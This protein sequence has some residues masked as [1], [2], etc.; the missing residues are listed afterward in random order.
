MAP[1]PYGTYEFN[2]G[3]ERARVADGR[4]FVAASEGATFNEVGTL[5]DPTFFEANYAIDRECVI[6]RR[7]PST[8]ARYEVR[9]RFSDGFEGANHVRDLVGP[10]R[11]WTGFT[12][13]SPKAPSVDAYVHLRD[14]I[15]SN[16]CDFVDAR[17]DVEGTQARSG[18]RALKATAAPKNADLVTSK[19][20]LESELVYFVEGDD[21][22]FSAA[23]LLAERRPFTL[24]DLESSWLDLGPGP[25]LAIDDDGALYVELKFGPKPTFRQAGPN[26]VAVPIGRWFQ[27]EVRYVLKA[28]DGGVIEVS[29][30]G[31]LILSATGWTLPLPNTILNSLEVGISATN[32][33]DGE[34]TVWVDDVQI[35]ASARPRAER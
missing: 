20:S 30:D 21:V 5:Y 35:E 2:L 1:D 22:R 7:D 27:V 28:F 12:L 34:T 32:H 10:A 24:F 33:V 26:K 8:D 4:G 15:L 16:D 19:A 14:C 6:S 29:Q 3:S 23:F 13:L 25:R 17:L 11:G 9:R 18:A 31:K